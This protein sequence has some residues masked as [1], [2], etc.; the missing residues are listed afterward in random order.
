MALD[1]NLH[2]C[3]FNKRVINVMVASQLAEVY[4]WHKYY[5]QISITTSDKTSD[6]RHGASTLPAVG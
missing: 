3:G 5:L 2:T 4:S 1:G 6:Y